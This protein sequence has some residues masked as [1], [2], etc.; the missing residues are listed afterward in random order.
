VISESFDNHLTGSMTWTIQRNR[1][2]ETRLTVVNNG[3]EEICYLYISPSDNLSWG[4][5]QLG[6]NDTIGVGERRTFTMREGKY[7]L[8]AEN[9]DHELIQTNT[10]NYLEGNMTWTISR[11]R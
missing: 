2:P 4:E 1:L 8:K 11:S 3:I 9:C 7:D 6:R 5:D 10:N